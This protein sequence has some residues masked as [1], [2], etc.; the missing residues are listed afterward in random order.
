MKGLARLAQ[1]LADANR[2][3][4]LRLLAR[5]ELCV[6][7]AARELGLSQPLV[8]QHLRVL[9]QAGLIQGERRGRRVHYHID[10]TCWEGLRRE[11]DELVGEARQGRGS[12]QK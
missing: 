10:R 7:A 9:R 2:L 11:L 12:K 3:R 6:T 1:A 4:L 8:S 5:R